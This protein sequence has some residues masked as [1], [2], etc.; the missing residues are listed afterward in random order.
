MLFRISVDVTHFLMRV[1][2]S[3]FGS[4]SACRQR[5]ASAV[6]TI[7]TGDRKCAVTATP[8]VLAASM[9]PIRTS[10]PLASIS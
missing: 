5:A 2:S 1:E 3:A 8:S 9:N 6:D 10:E 4:P 7:P